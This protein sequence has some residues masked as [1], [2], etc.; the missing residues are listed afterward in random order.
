MSRCLPTMPSACELHGQHQP[1][2]HLEA[3]LY[4][5]GAADVARVALAAGVLDVL[6]DGIEFDGQASMSASVR[7]ANAGTSV[8]AI[9]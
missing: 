9:V 5:D 1:A 8:I 4:G 3:A 2:R 7:C 6:A